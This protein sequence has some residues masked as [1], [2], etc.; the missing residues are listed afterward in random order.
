M[1][2]FS[3]PRTG[4]GHALYTDKEFIFERF[5]RRGYPYMTQEQ[6][7]KEL[8][9]ARY[10]DGRKYRNLFL[11]RLV[12]D[13]EMAG[14][15]Q[16]V[17]S[18]EFKKAYEIIC[19]WGELEKSGKLRK[20]NETNLEGEFLKEVFGEA[21]GYK[22]FSEN[23]DYWE[24]QQKFPVN[25]GQA[26][27]AIG[28]FESHRTNVPRAIIE[29]KGPTVNVDRD[30]SQGRT[31]VQQCW[32]YLNALPECPW[33]IVCNF[34]SFRLYHRNQT[35]RAYEL[36]TLQDL[37]KPEVFRQFYCIFQRDGILPSKLTQIPRIETLLDKS[38]NHEQ[39][40][41]D[42][43]YSYYHQNRIELIQHLTSDHHKK[44]LDTAIRITQKLIDRIVF[45][46]FCEDRALLP[47]NS[48]KKA[49]E[50]TPPFTHVTNPR[51]QNYIHLFASIDKGNPAAGISPFN[52]GLFR[53]DEEVD[54]LQL[55][56]QFTN[57][58]KNIGEY[59]FRDEINVDVLGHL[60][61]RS[62]NDIER[63]RTSGLFVQTQ[64]PDEKAVMS[65]SAERKRFGI[66]YT[67]SDFTEFIV[68]NTISKSAEQRF[69]A[70]AA[71]MKLKREAVEDTR[72]NPQAAAY[73]KECLAALRGIKIVDPACGSGAFLIKAYE[74][75]EG[76]YLD[77]LTHLAY[78]G[79]NV[80]A[81]KEAVPD[82]IL[83]ENIHGMD[84]SSEA[85]EITQLALWI[86]SAHRGK[87]LA[88]LSKNIICG[89]S[90][91]DDP[92]VD[93]KARDWK[94]TFPAVFERENPG[95][96]CVIGNPPWERMKLQEREFFDGRDTKI[97][98]ATSAAKRRELIEKLEKKNPD[99][100]ALYQQ[101][102][103]QA[104]AN[105]DYIR[106]SKRYPLT[107]TGD[108]NTYAVFAELAHTIVSPT[109]KVGFLVP[110][111]I[112]TD[113][114]T[115]D[116]F[117]TLIETKALS[118]LYDFENKAPVFTDVHRSFKFTVLLF[119][120]VRQTSDSVDFVFFAHRMK[121]LEDS[122]RH[123]K[124]AADDIK[125]MNPNTKTC[126]IFRS[127][128]DSEITKSVYRK[129]PVLIDKT[130]KKG[131]NPWGIKFFTMFHQTND[132]ELFHTA[133]VLKEMKCKR[134]GAI[135]K[136]GKQVF[137][138]LYEAKM[139]QMYDHRAASVVIN[140]E[141][142]FRQ[143]QTASTSSAQHQNP[144]YVTEPRWW[145]ESSEIEKSTNQY[146]HPAFLAFKNV[147][148]PTNQRTMIAAFVPKY[149]VINS[150]PIIL[151]DENIPVNKQACFLANFNAFSFDY[152]VR[153]KIGNVNLNFFLIEQL[154][155]FGPDFYSDKCPWDKKKT[156]EQWI[157][158]RVL[159][160]TCTSNDMI[161]LAKAA[162]FKP[163]V[164]KWKDTER[165]KLMAE[166]DAAF[167]HLYSIGR[168]D[169]SYIL[170]T[171]SGVVK[172]GQSVFEDTTEAL[173][174]NCYDQFL[175]SR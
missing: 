161:P 113:N 100:F 118:G 148:S 140:E 163:G 39:E 25:G 96:D 48:L 4:P 92:A 169:V 99:L 129:V 120:G 81:L 87:T 101:A 52:G 97:A 70:I 44:P 69:D 145:A 26:D 137:L 20:L 84:L 40:V 94:K 29:L 85:V 5:G 27:G 62:V 127:S 128:R 73:W 41:G 132:A 56:D 51:W 80:D 43:L 108:I 8:N 21:L 98:T 158:E 168:D 109:G 143:G 18:A 170:S 88:D 152:I 174:L 63:I 12:N 117:A 136:K 131:G 58:F 59:D 157:S 138:P 91:I 162:G 155:A 106:T 159:K 3:R 102:Q 34:V 79:E 173:I 77:I 71:Q 37:A 115:K 124:L 150:A 49:W 31:P 121:E 23:L 154:P 167:F 151:F 175:E 75:L 123:I 32:D 50:Q 112:A 45:I 103:K 65:K 53:K 30:K 95:F 2:Y 72:N 160:L 61:E 64:E 6:L 144:E 68:H 130:R 147:T 89:N 78:Q 104:E 135:W 111:G 126:P 17:D 164:H 54:S 86:R 93:P 60:F 139:I 114:T 134:D 133:E 90:L 22:F 13:K 149:G 83:H 11:P 47:T 1:Y 171:F 146:P 28:F 142:W 14:N 42:K 82:Y 116:F 24:C 9:T 156:L 107:G 33:G 35:P 16:L 153:Q 110:S 19:K 165:R 122:K 74:T 76:L 105:L 119:G 10:G 67:P 38:I 46:A 7:F 141:N 15:K 36:F 57:V 125:M 172:E 66:Y 166:L 55:D